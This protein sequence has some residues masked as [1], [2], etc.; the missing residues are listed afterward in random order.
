MHPDAHGFA[1]E[2]GFGNLSDEAAV[3][4]II[5]I[6]THDK[7]LAL[8]DIVFSV[9]ARVARVSNE[10]V[11]LSFA[12]LLDESRIHG[13]GVR[14]L[15]ESNRLTIDRQMMTPVDNPV[16]RQADDAFYVVDA[17]IR[18]QSKYD[19]ITS[20]RCPGFDNLR[21]GHRKPQAI[22]LLFDENEIALQQSRHHRT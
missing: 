6:I 19:D 9:L 14:V 21:F 5:A 11:V 3:D 13:R 22:G 20:S 17:R 18:R 10:N 8:A 12:E 7:I 15:F 1:D 16:T 4:T 2:V